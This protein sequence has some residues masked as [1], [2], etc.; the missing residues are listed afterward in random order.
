[1]D[2]LIWIWIIAIVL[3]IIY[4]L[5]KPSKPPRYIQI[6]N[7]DK[8]QLEDSEE[9][10]EEDFEEIPKKSYIDNNGYERDYYDD[11]L[12][13]RKVAYEYLYNYPEEHSERFRDYDVHHK[14]EN[15]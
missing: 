15:K 4:K 1:M 13:H 5:S 7:L 2:I 9:D 6:T 10:F 3:W 12:I 11:R 14:D 8:N